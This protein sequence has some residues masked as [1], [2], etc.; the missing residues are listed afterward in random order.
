MTDPIVALDDQTVDRIAAGEVVERPASVVKELL[1]NSLDADSSRITVAVEAGGTESIRVSDDGVGMDRENLRRSVEKHTTSKISGLEDLEG[2]LQ[3]LGFR[4]EALHAIGAVA[5]VTITSKPRGGSRGSSLTIDGGE[6]TTI[7]SAGCPEGTTVSVSDLFYNVPARRKY[8]KQ[9]PTE[10]DHI[11]RIVTGYAL[12][13]PDVA[14][15]LEHNGRERFTTSG[16]G[17]LRSTV[18]AVYGRDVASAMLPVEAAGDS[19]PEGPLDS[20]TGLVSH[21]ETTRASRSYCLAFVNGRY[22]TAQSVREAII[23]AYGSQLAADRYPFAVVS[24]AVDPATVDVNVHPRKLAVRFT[25]EPAVQKQVSSAVESALLA[26]GVLRTRAPRGQSAPEQ[27]TIEPETTADSEQDIEQSQSTASSTV[28][29]TASD[30]SQDTTSTDSSPAPQQDGESRGQ[31]GRIRAPTT[32][33]ELDSAQQR[34]ENEASEPLNDDP[35]ESSPSSNTAN[36][37]PSSFDPTQLPSMKILGQLDDTYVVGT[38]DNGLIL[39]D[40][41]AADER[42]NYE[43]LQDEFSGETAV[44]T[45]AEPVTVELTA[46]EATLFDRYRDA[47]AQVGFHTDGANDRTVVVNSVP[48]LV[49]DAGGPELV[50]EVLGEFATEHTPTTVETIVD[51]LLA[52]LAC[53]PSITANESLTDGSILE[54]LSALDACENPYACP[55]GRPVLIEIDENEIETRFERDYPGHQG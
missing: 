44:Q 36:P 10:F 52:D 22:I 31:P 47:L 50:R 54:L 42:I 6:R 17:E 20:V 7:E 51:A 12:A 29:S 46:R 53:Y 16:R 37:S 5:R 21:P 40:Q 11:Q 15:T 1:E 39:I 2:G 14:I 19:L 49:A 13:N 26:E 48:A 43:H 34:D 30:S 23:D 18:L 4:G 9:E 24:V 45:L 33:L 32:Q 25:D 8:L 28:S 55:H 27:A 38:T 35:V 41:H 3:S